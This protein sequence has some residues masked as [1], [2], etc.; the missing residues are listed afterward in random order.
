MPCGDSALAATVRPVQA[1]AV[2]A[3]AS[4]M[5]LSL[6][7]IFIVSPNFSSVDRQYYP[8]RASITPGSFDTT[9][10]LL[11]AG[12]NSAPRRPRRQEDRVSWVTVPYHGAARERL[13][14]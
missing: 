7:L 1:Q 11:K 4:S 12:E 10:A 14:Q 3:A 6:V 5:V 8:C 13:H 9:F 2:A